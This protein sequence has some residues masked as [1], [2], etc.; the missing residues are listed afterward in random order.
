MKA[1]KFVI[2]S[3]LLCSF[4]LIGEVMAYGPNIHHYDADAEFDEDGVSYSVTSSGSHTYTAVAVDNGDYCAPLS[5]RIY[6]DDRYVEDYSQIS[7]RITLKGADQQYFAEQL[8]VKL[9]VRGFDNVT[10]INDEELI[11][12]L[13]QDTPHGNSEGLMVMSYALPSEVYSGS[14]HDPLLKWL[15]AGGS[16]YWAMSP[17][18]M[19]SRNNGV[20]SEVDNNQ[21]LL[22]G[23][24]DA[25]NLNQ[26][27]VAVTVIETDG[28]TAA[29]SLKWNRVLYGIDISGI[30]G[31]KS[32]GYIY[33][34][35]SS[36]SFVPHGDGMICV[37]GGNTFRDLYDDIAQ[38]IA[39]G[40][41]CHSRNIATDEGSVTRGTI[42]NNIEMKIEGNA[43]IYITI[44]GHY[45]VYGRTVYSI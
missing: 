15:D 19:F 25:I 34:G 37:F 20:V 1:D 18:G 4:I 31:A 14:E 9:K 45:A 23:K 7:D 5:L 17:A 13:K 29:L 26:D 36:V 10:V 30:D 41:S 11:D 22:F 44:G 40:I 38:V 3:I 16:L 21:T 8:T 27:K 35:Y 42:Y 39:S 32:I 6:I 12:F 33:D 2:L 24:S 43:S 28:L